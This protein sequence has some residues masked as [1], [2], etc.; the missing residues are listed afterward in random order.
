MHKPWQGLCWTFGVLG[1]TFDLER[2]TDK[3]IVVRDKP[4]RVEQVV[5]EVDDIIHRGCLLCQR[6]APVCRN[7]HVQQDTGC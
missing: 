5:K 6:K 2:A 4:S 1:V 7:S 3:V